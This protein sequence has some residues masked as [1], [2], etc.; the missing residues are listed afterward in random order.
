MR[1][2]PA[3]SGVGSYAASQAASEERR[4]LERKADDKGV[5]NGDDDDNSE[6]GDDDS[7]GDD[8]DAEDTGRAASG[9]ASLTPSPSRD[10]SGQGK[11]WHDQTAGRAAFSVAN[12][13]WND[14]GS[15]SDNPL[16]REPEGESKPNSV[17]DSAYLPRSATAEEV[18]E[19]E[20][21]VAT[22][23]AVSG[24]TA[25]SK[26]QP[27]G[28]ETRAAAAAPTAEP[29]SSTHQ[30]KEEEEKVMAGVV[31]SSAL[32]DKGGSSARDRQA[33]GVVNGGSS[34]RAAEE[35][36]RKP[37]PS[38]TSV[39]S[40][41][42]SGATAAMKEVLPPLAE[43]MTTK[44]TDRPRE[45]SR[46]ASKPPRGALVTPSQAV[47]AV[48][49]TGRLVAEVAVARDGS[50]GNAL[51]VGGTDVE[52]VG[53]TS[54]TLTPAELTTAAAAAAGEMTVATM[55]FDSGADDVLFQPAMPANTAIPRYPAVSSSTRAP[56]GAVGLGATTG[57]GAAAS[58]TPQER[59]GQG[60]RGGGGVLV[61]SSS[62]LGE[63]DEDELAEESERLQREGNR[64]KR[65]A[66]TV[67][68]E[69]KDEVRPSA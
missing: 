42:G 21:V 34:A 36:E 53:G 44:A 4:R 1:T 51:D 55:E 16:P 67:T 63:M 60:Q 49:A 11:S 41:S 26:S 18:P 30:Q 56:A 14:A 66:E 62:Y 27:Q 68:E 38:G 65:D 20:G 17:N 35:L 52:V 9:G 37:G 8:V 57:G 3:A 43:I 24:G 29:G 58:Q 39:D 6:V 10:E 22:G 45:G 15:A 7:V 59:E 50:A 31:L 13:G 19:S 28:G 33:Q 5:N 64:A 2:G 40:A 47:S 25:G 54:V 32:A 48:E 61:G 69:M 46:G 12:A 23:L